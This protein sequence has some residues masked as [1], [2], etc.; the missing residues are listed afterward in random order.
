[1]KFEYIL[2]PPKRWTFEQ[3]KLKLF[4]EKWCKGKVLN[5]FAGKTRLNVDE[6]RVDSSEEFRPDQCIDA[7]EFLNTTNLKFDTIVLDPPYSLRKSYEKYKGHYIGSTW[8]QIRRAVPRVCNEGARVI[9][10]GYNS[11]G[12]SRTLG[13]EKIAICLVCHNGDHNDTVVT[14]E[15]SHNKSQNCTNCGGNLKFVGSRMINGK[16]YCM[17]CFVKGNYKSS[18]IKSRTP[19]K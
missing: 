6:F 16:R 14:V 3:P 9:S 4:I 17:K 12:M 15:S 7:L 13:F 11:Q 18:G 8:T 1:M 2:Q 10:L 5:L 19:S